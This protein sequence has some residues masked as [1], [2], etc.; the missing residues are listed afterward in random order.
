MP[1]EEGVGFE[2]QQ[3]SF[4]VLDATG[5]AGEP[6]A[7]GL[8]KGELVDLTVEDD[9]L[10]PE[11]SILGNQF[12]STVREVGGGAE[13]NRMTRGLGEMEESSFERRE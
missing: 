5:E 12:G 6:E 13:N 7:I 4:P 11:E 9:E 8:R 2:D 3:A 10:L 1:A